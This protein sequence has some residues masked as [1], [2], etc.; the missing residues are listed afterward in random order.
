MPDSDD[1]K[2]DA[3]Q[4]EPG[5]SIATD[6]VSLH[7]RVAALEAKLDKLLAELARHVSLRMDE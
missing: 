4:P 1:V 7:D 5:E 6:P 2:K 3:P